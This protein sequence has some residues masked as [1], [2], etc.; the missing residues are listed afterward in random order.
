MRDSEDDVVEEGEEIGGEAGD[1][2]VMQGAAGRAGQGQGSGDGGDGDDGAALGRLTAAAAAAQA[3]PLA[4]SLAAPATGGSGARRGSEMERRGEEKVRGG[5]ERKAQACGW[6]LILH[7]ALPCAQSMAFA[8]LL[9]ERI[10]QRYQREVGD[11][12]ADDRTAA[13]AT[14]SSGAST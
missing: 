9:D 4:A 12:F 7:L 11:I 2:E 5:P 13:P 1:D 6:L 8:Q 10:R 14:S 3:A